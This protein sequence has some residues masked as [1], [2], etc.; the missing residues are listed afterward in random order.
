MPVDAGHADVH[1]H[2]R[3]APPAGEVDGSEAVRGLADDREARLRLEDRAEPRP[4]E[5]LV[6][7]DQH[8]DRTVRGRHARTV[9]AAR[10][11][12]ITPAGAC[13]DHPRGGRRRRAAG[14]GSR[15]AGARATRGFAGRADAAAA[16]ALS[17]LG[18]V[19]AFARGRRRSAERADRRGDP[20]GRL[21]PAR[22]AR[23]RR[24]A[25]GRRGGERAARRWTRTAAARRS[26]R[27]CW[28]STR[29]APTPARRA[30]AAGLALVLAAMVFL[31]FTDPVV[32]P[33]A[34]AFV[35]PLC[36]GVWAAGL[37]VASRNRLAAE[38]AARSRE[39]ERRREE[40]ARLAVE[41]ERMRLTAELDR[42]ARG[43]VE[44]MIA[45]AAA[46]EAA[47]AGD[48]D[49]VRA[50]FAPARVGRPRLAQRDAGAAR[51]AALGRGARPRAAADAGPPGRA[52][53]RGAGRRARRRRWTWTGSRG[54]S[55]AASSWPPT[56]SCSTRSPRPAGA[57]CGSG[58][59]TGRRRC[60]SRSREPRPRGATSRWRRS[61]S[62]S[63]R[64]A[65]A[66][67]CTRPMR[68]GR[69][70]APSSPAAH[71]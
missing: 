59:A 14:L 17:A 18:L 67:P 44:E 3:R 5:R 43:R 53:G 16:L 63:A 4:H 13:A 11:I 46:G 8:G 55:S 21:A 33:A 39:L 47:L 62:A 52:A 10:A 31:T 22:A 54:R 36:A 60:C 57:A 1:Q 70:C 64:T 6:V 41:V 38:L 20:A 69:C 27:R 23:R 56:G 34:L 24:G 9:A 71:A 28:C 12:R 29:S 25:R 30:S 68:A 42:A 50:A 32:S 49:G 19:G 45:L 65:G 66:W 61:A 26:P 51:G 15:H 40:T 7:G 2:D 48:P 58:C 35:L 37:V